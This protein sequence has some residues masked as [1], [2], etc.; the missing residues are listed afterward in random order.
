[1]LVEK[2]VSNALLFD[3]AE[4]MHL[5]FTQHSS[6]YIFLLVISRKRKLILT[7][8]GELMVKLPFT[9]DEANTLVYGAKQGW[10]HET[11]ALVAIKSSKP[12]PILTAFGDDEANRLNLSRYFPN[13]ELKEQNS[14]AVANLAAYIHWYMHWNNIRRHEIKDHFKNCTLARSGEGV[15]SHFFDDYS[16]THSDKFSFNVGRGLLTWTKC[17]V[18]GVVNILSTPALSSRLQISSKQPWRLYTA[19]MSTQNGSDVNLLNLSGTET[20]PYKLDL[21]PS[22]LFMVRFMAKKCQQQ[23]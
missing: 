23:L 9:V 13:V 17:I 18:S 10:L 2:L 12:M 16:L 11:L 4:L 3:A 7:E 20:I 5:L 1:M 8:H 15:S 21:T 6:I 22:L 14:V 19:L